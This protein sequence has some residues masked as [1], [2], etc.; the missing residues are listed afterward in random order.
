[1]NKANNT[2]EDQYKE[3]IE[4]NSNGIII[5]RGEDIIFANHSCQKITGYTH[6]E[7]LKLKFWELAYNRKVVKERGLK[8]QKGEKVIDRYEEQVKRKDNT[9]V[10]VEY[11]A[12]NIIWDGE[13]AI[14][15]SFYDISKQ[16]KIELQLLESEKRYKAL[17][18]I[19]NEAI[20]FSN[21]GIGIDCNK[22]AE[23]MFG[24]TREEVIGMRGTTIVS[25]KYKPLIVERMLSNYA[26]PYEAVGL[27]KNGDEFPIEVQGLQ[28]IYN[29]KATRVT[30]VRDISKQ[31]E[32]E[33]NFIKSEN[34]YQILT[35]SLTDCVFMLDINGLFT[36][37]SPVFTKITDFK[38]EEF[39]GR[40]FLEGIADDYH[41]KI[42]SIFNTGIQEFKNNLYEI[43][44]VAKGGNR[45]PTEISSSTLLDENNIPI[46]RIGTFRDITNR[47]INERSLIIAKEKAEESDKLKTAFLQNMSHE[48][49]TPLNGILGFADLLR[50]EYTPSQDVMKYSSIIYK[51]GSRLQSLINNVLDISKIEAGSVEVNIKPFVLNHL[52]KDIEN[53]LKSKAKEKHLTLS[54]LLDLEDEDS[55]ILSDSEKL[56]QIIINL[57][58]NAIK[59]TSKGEVILSY[60]IEKNN[61]RFAVKDTGLGLSPENQK[62]VFNRFYQTDLS[63]KRGFEGAGLGLAITKDLVE[64]LKGEIGV[65]SEENIGTEFW[66]RIPYQKGSST[67]VRVNIKDNLELFYKTIH[68]LIAEDD[69]ANY[70]YLEALLSKY[71]VKLSRAVNG[72]EAIDYCENNNV[73]LVLMDINMPKTDGLEA[74]KIIKE[75]KSNLPIIVQSAS[76]FEG[77]KKAAFDAGCDAFISKPIIKKD[78]LQQ[79]KLFF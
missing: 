46:G 36:Y 67:N 21:N 41:D 15:G 20:F 38:V 76:A 58:N 69:D 50:T 72:D 27:K 4:S 48:I 54:I 43:E 53:L 44:I 37:L 52:L 63:K 12:K 45:I 33:I 39:I 5:Y 78:L 11:S 23:R 3:L 9:F 59:F 34:K 13:P 14:M 74:T 57:I 47:K 28:I 31:K 19:T 75:L 64:L 32:S 25:D 1:M 77:D 40:H 30:I 2:I 71:N 70:L 24:Y 17:A 51:S 73:D 10:W 42:I 35:E 29:N 65:N 68:I 18:N 60:S 66:F 16:K 62:L 7:I 55:L 79:I 26:E 8:R 56:N 22:T 61:I 49:R 6:P